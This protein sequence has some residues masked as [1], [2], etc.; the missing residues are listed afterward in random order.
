MGRVYVLSALGGGRST[1]ARASIEK[2]NGVPI[3]ELTR[4]LLELTNGDTAA[5][6]AVILSARWWWFYW[7]VFGAPATFEIE[8][9][10]PSGTSISRVPA[11]KQM[12]SWI[13]ENNALDF[14]KAF[15][16]WQINKETSVLTVNTFDWVDKN[17]F[18]DF[19]RRSFTSLKDSATKNL[20]NGIRK[21]GGGDDDMWKEGILP[22]IATKRY[23]HGSTF[24]LRVIEGRQRDGQKVGDLVEGQIQ[25]WVEPSRDKHLL[26]E[27][28]VYIL[29][30]GARYSSAVLVA[31]VVQD[32]SFGRLV[33]TGG[34]A[35]TRQ[36]GGVQTHVLPNS[37]LRIV[38]P[39]FVLDRPSGARD[40]EFLVPDVPLNDDPFDSE[41]VGTNLRALVLL[42]AATK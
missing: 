26:F 41:K 42:E 3:H 36:S 13:Q 12:P 28:N 17:R 19:T 18:Y 29:I 38:V 27:G 30:G 21:N 6:R 31:N 5:L 10:L 37:Q 7:K 23:R 33:G 8:L 9:K 15:R 22:Y 14:D 20:V 34:Y 25:S 40:P 32:F 24:L 35:R 16:F 1:D 2:I 4:A 39:R 11:S